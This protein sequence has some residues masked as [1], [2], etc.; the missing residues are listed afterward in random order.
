MRRGVCYFSDV[1]AATDAARNAEEGE[2]KAQL[3]HLVATWGRWEFGLDRPVRGMREL[4]AGMEQWTYGFR[5]GRNL[6]ERH[7]RLSSGSTVRLSEFWR[8]PCVAHILSQVGR[9]RR[10]VDAHRVFLAGLAQETG[11]RPSDLVHAVR[12]VGGPTE[13][14]ERRLAYISTKRKSYLSGCDKQTCAVCPYVGRPH[15]HM[16]G[17]SSCLLDLS[18]AGL[19]SD[20][21][22]RIPRW[23]PARVRAMQIKYTA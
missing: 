18:R 21:G 2:R 12:T 17:P 19:I 13:E 8:L 22:R 20:D 7:H 3:A 6:A 4:P 1:E 16:D 9:S 15:P 5:L 11:L 23:P 10:V 14:L